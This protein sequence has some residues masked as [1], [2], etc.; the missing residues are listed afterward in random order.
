MSTRYVPNTF[1]QNGDGLNDWFEIYGNINDIDF[2][3]LRVFNRFGEEVF[4]TENKHFKWDGTY[5][6]QPLL[7]N[8]FVYTLEISVLGDSENKLLKG[9]IVLLR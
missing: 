5:K 6:G 8:T 7:P 1:S 9:S 2:I 4:K 3:S